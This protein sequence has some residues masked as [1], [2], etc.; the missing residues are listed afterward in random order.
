MGLHHGCVCMCVGWGARGSGAG[1]SRTRQ[2]TRQNVWPKK[3]LDSA[4][5]EG[6]GRPKSW[7]G[8]PP[9]HCP[10][11]AGRARTCVPAWLSSRSWRRLVATAQKDPPAAQH[12][13]SSP[14]AY[15][16]GGAWVRSIL[17]LVV[18]VMADWHG[19]CTLRHRLAPHARGC[20]LDFRRLPADPQPPAPG[21]LL[22]TP[23]QAAHWAA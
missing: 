19:A 8:R 2:M 9:R 13:A 23:G 16:A 7:I 18:D 3:S 20:S 17:Y 1:T 22:S 4:Q 12:S 11:A 10:G 5:A 21:S 15:T 14:S 6:F